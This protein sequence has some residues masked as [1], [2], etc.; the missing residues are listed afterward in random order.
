MIKTMRRSHRTLA[1]AVFIF[2]ACLVSSSQST[3]FESAS[4]CVAPNSSE[5]VV[6]CGQFCESG[7]ISLKIDD[8][9]VLPWPK[10]ESLK[11]NG[12][13]ANARHRVVIYRAGK[14][15]QSFKFRFSEFKLNRA[16]LFLND[17]YWTAQLWDTKQ[18][19][20]CK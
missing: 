14:P 2:V 19:P 12:L 8:Q 3:E 16:C 17:L 13:D 11:I 6:R 18:A 15:Q 7:K 1:V 10:A 4:L 5:A 9:P 20:W